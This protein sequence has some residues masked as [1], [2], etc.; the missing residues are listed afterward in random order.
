MRDKSFI[1][2]AR[3][4]AV[5]LKVK[6]LKNSQHKALLVI[7]AD[8]LEKTGMILCAGGKKPREKVVRHYNADIAKGRPR[9]S[10]D[11]EAEVDALIQDL[12][13]ELIMTTRGN[14]ETIDY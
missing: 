1:Q 12:G 4:M 3:E 5:T 6:H 13:L 9:L 7:A 10:M 8:D 2:E 11:T 14:I